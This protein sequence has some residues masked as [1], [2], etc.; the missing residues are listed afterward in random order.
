MTSVHQFVPNFS[1]GD[2][3]G[4]HTVQVKRL[5]RSAGFESQ[6]FAEAMA[7]DVR[8]EARPWSDY[9]R[10]RRP[11]DLIIYQCSTG[12]RMVAFLRDRREPLAVNYHN[13]TPAVFFDRWE[14]VA[15]G[16]MRRA[17][18]E[19][20]QLAPRTQLA[21][22]VSA[23]NAAELAGM[24]FPDPVV[25]P[26]LLDLA[27]LDAEPDARTLERLRRDAR[28]GTRWLFV[29]RVA[30]NKCQH[31]VIAAFAAYR[32]LHNPAA[33][34]TLVGGFTSDQYRWS[35]EAMAAELGIAEA[36]ELAGSVTAPELV[37]HFRGADVFVCLSEHEGFCVP[38]IEAMHLGVPV[39]AFGAAAVPDT[40]GDAG[41]L[42]PDK[43]P[44]VVATAV[45]HLL[46]D[47]ELSESMRRA[48]RQRAED[49]ALT[50][51]APRM[52][53]VVEDFLSRSQPAVPAAV[54]R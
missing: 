3:I 28:G 38:V 25:V 41:V 39:V 36:V 30:P 4:H 12:S 35:L 46:A 18:D 11:A 29:G 37:A 45:E 21:I 8:Q 27:S 5:L 31:D 53:E 34:L 6:I 16:S 17:R 22:A 1:A 54:P 10:R 32:R 2:A 26:L 7:P 50:R 43:D 47:P 20:R 24:G 44:V 23:F 13:I 33:R 51:T 48:G 14:P 49:F 15:A 52:L 9:G 19:L 42:L 40:I